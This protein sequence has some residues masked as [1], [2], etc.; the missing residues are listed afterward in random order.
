MNIRAGSCDKESMDPK[1]L[2]GQARCL[3][4][5]GD[6]QSELTGGRIR[7]E[8]YGY[9][10]IGQSDSWT[11]KFKSQ[12]FLYRSAGEDRSP[13]QR[14]ADGPVLVFCSLS[15]FRELD[16]VPRTGVLSSPKP[17]VPEPVSRSTLRDTALWTSN[18][19]GKLTHGLLL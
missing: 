19:P 12:D 8:L 3:K 14:R 1:I 6:I 9:W 10:E 15:A 18:S 13:C 5:A 16:H 7:M 17:L 2:F 11:L 4:A